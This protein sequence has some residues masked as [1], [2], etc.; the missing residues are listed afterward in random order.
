[1]SLDRFRE[2]YTLDRRVR[3]GVPPHPLASAERLLL[4]FPGYPV[5]IVALVL[6]DDGPFARCQLAR[7]WR[8]G[9]RADL[10]GVAD[11]AAAGR[12]GAPPRKRR[13]PSRPPTGDC[14]PLALLVS[15][16]VVTL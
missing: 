10:I 12:A 6:E 5:G 11:R 13:R 14:L 15:P 2:T 8:R 1:L 4:T 16:S 7:S 3:G 9:P